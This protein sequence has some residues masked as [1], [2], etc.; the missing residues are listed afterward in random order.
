[1]NDL[2]Y[3]WEEANLSKISSYLDTHNVFI[4]M[5]DKRDKTYSQIKFMYV[6]LNEL[7]KEFYGDASKET[8]EELKNALYSDF[9]K[10]NSLD[11]YRT[12][13]ASVTEM[14]LFIDWLIKLMAQQYGI[15][16]ALDLVEE[17]FK[18]SWIYAMTCSRKC[19][20]C[21]KPHADIH[22]TKRIGAGRDRTTVDH[23]KYKV[24]SL[25]REHHTIEHLTGILLKNNG[26]YGV[27]LSKYDFD[28]LGIKGTYEEDIKEM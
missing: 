5:Q 11:F 9:C 26:L 17:D 3:K 28:E 8:V 22:H 24:I 18:S 25:C 10:A 23:T 2:I 15:T 27:N 12:K 21:G 4:V 1:M 16:L 7:A 20:I 14:K 6:L 13:T 19:V